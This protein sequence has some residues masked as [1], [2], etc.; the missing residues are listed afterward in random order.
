MNTHNEL[1]QILSRHR[2]WLLSKEATG[3]RADLS[4]AVLDDRD[5]SGLNL[6]GAILRGASL[7]RA[8]LVGT[9]LVH[10]DLSDATLEGAI[11]R[12]TNLLL[13][14]FT[15]ADLRNADLSS[16]TPD[17]ENKL[18]ASRQGPRFKDADLRGANLTGCYCHASDFAGAVL[19]G[20]SFSSADLEQANLSGNCLDNLDLSGANLKDADLRGSKLRGANLKVADLDHADLSCALLSNAD[21][22]GASLKSTN[23]NDTEVDGIKYDRKAHYRGIRVASCHGSARFRRAAQDQDFIE[24]YK[25]A[26][27]LNYYLWLWVT[28]CGRSMTRV[29][30]WSMGISLAFGLIYYCLGEDAFS[31]SFNETLPWSLYRAICFSLLTCTTLG[32][33][34]MAPKTPLASGLVTL[35]SVIGYVMLGML[36]SILATKLARRS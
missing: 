11:M 17:T 18:G 31:Y 36:I 9:Q 32:Y 22:S 16:A 35:E 10:A 30:L 3:Q 21:V 24:E 6:S 7:R 14:D 8:N 12:K 26:H 34:D 4:G 5:L 25:E 20:A 2:D 19:E 29:V 27:R 15:G 13:A 1:S 33:G 23:F 28:D